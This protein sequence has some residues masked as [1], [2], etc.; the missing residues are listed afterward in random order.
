M[1][2]TVILAIAGVA[3]AMSLIGLGIA[4]GKRSPLKR[5]CSAGEEERGD[6]EKCASCSCASNDNLGFDSQR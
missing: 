3:I 2:F 5:S 1:I 4:L 6:G